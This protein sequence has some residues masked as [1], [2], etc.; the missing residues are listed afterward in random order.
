MTHS[1]I[2]EKEKAPVEICMI[3]DYA[4]HSMHFFPI[5]EM[6]LGHCPLGG[7]QKCLKSIQSESWQKNEVDKR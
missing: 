5:Y 4:S 1:G 6:R 2:K 7:N 3:L